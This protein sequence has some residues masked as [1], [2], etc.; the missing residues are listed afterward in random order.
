MIQD[1]VRNHQTFH[2]HSYPP[3]KNNLSTNLEPR[4]QPQAALGKHKETEQKHWFGVV[5][6]CFVTANETILLSKKMSV[7]WIWK[8]SK[9]ETR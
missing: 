5:L 9:Q 6:G 7:V 4:C 3:E 8:V 2:L 1:P